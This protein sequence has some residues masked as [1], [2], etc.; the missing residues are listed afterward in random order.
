MKNRW[1]W[2]FVVAPLL[3]FTPLAA[4]A[5]DVLDLQE[6]KSF[7]IGY[8]PFSLFSLDSYNQPIAV[9]YLVQNDLTV[10][11]SSGRSRDDFHRAGIQYKSNE[12]SLWGRYNLLKHL[13]ISARL[14]QLNLE[15]RNYTSNSAG[16]VRAD[17]SGK[18]AANTLGIG[19]GN[20]WVWE[21]GLSI[22]VDWVVANWAYGTKDTHQINSNTGVAAADAESAANL[23]ASQVKTLANLPD[24]AVFSIGYL[25]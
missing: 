10:G 9:G 2:L 15:Y 25:F 23:D 4:H 20:R 22:G 11:V 6:G 7:Y 3:G 12:S 19:V 8:S 24:M 13:E 16:T 18:L 21:N 5:D 17:Y 14:R 1:L